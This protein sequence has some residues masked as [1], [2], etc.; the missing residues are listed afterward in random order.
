MP[1]PLLLLIARLKIL[2]NLANCFA[3]ELLVVVL[4][5]LITF[6]FLVFTELALLVFGHATHLFLAM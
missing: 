6:T 3:L 4:L 2:E 1:M 5:S